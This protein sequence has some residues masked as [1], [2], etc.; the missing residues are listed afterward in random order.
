MKHEFILSLVTD[1]YVFDHG[2]DALCAN[3]A[4]SLL[5][6]LPGRLKVVV[7]DVRFK[8]AMPFAPDY[9]D[10]T[11]RLFRGGVSKLRSVTI[12]PDGRVMLFRE[13]SDALEK[14]FPDARKLW[15]AV[16]AVEE[17]IK[18]WL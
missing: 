17:E 6:R 9:G 12:W 18:Q 7:A 10:G 4:D 11:A 14:A 3:V 5:G 8:G 15:F 1:H 2:R 16:E 13:A